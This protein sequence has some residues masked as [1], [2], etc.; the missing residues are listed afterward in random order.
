M[1]IRTVRDLIIVAVVIALGI[2]A[3][4]WFTAPGVSAEQA[5]TIDSLRAYNAV[6]D[7][8]LTEA[9][10]QQ[11]ALRR[12]TLRRHRADSIVSQQREDS[13][14]ALIP[15]TAT[16]VLRPIHD[17]IVA[18]KNSTIFMLRRDLFVSDSLLDARTHDLTALR[19]QNTALL[20]QVNDLEEKAG[21]GLLRRLKVAAP[22]VA[23]TFGACKLKL[24]E[25]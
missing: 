20:A 21:M 4:R 18:A 12:G 16:V 7:T 2:A 19:I 5:H 8:N 13:L 17:A 10:R 11:D 23:G 6:L 1:K 22:F 14:E 25:C 3:F 9:L 24:I 15:D